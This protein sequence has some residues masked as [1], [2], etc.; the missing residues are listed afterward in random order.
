MKAKELKELLKDV[1]DNAEI[2]LVYT[3]KVFPLELKTG[4]AAAVVDDLLPWNQTVYLKVAAAVVDDLLPWNQTV[5]LQVGDVV[6][7]F[8]CNMGDIP[9]M[10]RK[11]LQ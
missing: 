4:G 9:D 1:N 8:T 5:Y 3:R 7:Y 2:R 6:G 10:I 11:D